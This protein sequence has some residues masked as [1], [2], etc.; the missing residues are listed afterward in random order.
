[1]GT[2]IDSDALLFSI[3][4]FCRRCTETTHGVGY[5]YEPCHNDLCPM[6]F[7][8]DEIVKMQS[9][10]RLGETINNTVNAEVSI[11]NQNGMVS[12]KSNNEQR[13]SSKRRCPSCGSHWLSAEYC[14]NCGARTVEDDI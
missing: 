6:K 4:R 1:M 10:A 8:S 3:Y 2:K 14:C 13:T 9:D 12:T 11:N 7:V 5:D